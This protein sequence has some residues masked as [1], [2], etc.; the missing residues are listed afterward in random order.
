MARKILTIE[1][2]T[3]QDFFG[4]EDH[5]DDKSLLG[6][7]VNEFDNDEIVATLREDNAPAPDRLEALQDAVAAF[8]SGLKEKIL[9]P[10]AYPELPDWIRP[11][12]R[13]LHAALVASK[14]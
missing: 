14:V 4:S 7:L 2:D 5:E 3:D 8:E 13:D 1:Y 11:L 6:Y 12:T 10:L 9:N